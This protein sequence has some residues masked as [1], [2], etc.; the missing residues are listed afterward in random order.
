MCRP[1]F[2]TWRYSQESIKRTCGFPMRAGGG[3]VACSANGSLCVTFSQPLMK[4]PGANELVQLSEARYDSVLA[5]YRKGKRRPFRRTGTHHRRWTRSWRRF[6]LAMF[7]SLGRDL[8]VSFRS[9]SRPVGGWG[10]LW[11]V[12]YLRVHL[13]GRQD[14]CC[15]RFLLQ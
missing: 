7:S 4:H 15:Y 5:G 12:L 9:T 6:F 1:C 11:Y 13:F 2:L 8:G 3:G 14:Y 10:G